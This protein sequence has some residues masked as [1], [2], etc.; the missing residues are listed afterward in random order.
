MASKRNSLF[1]VAL[2]STVTAG[3]RALQAAPLRFWSRK[4]LSRQPVFIVGAPRSGSTFL[5]Q[6]LTNIFDVAYIDNLAARFAD[7]LPLAMWVSRVCF[8][9]K[10]HNSFTSE[11]GR[12]QGL[13]SP[14]ECGAFWYRWL[15][16]DEHYVAPST[17][18]PYVAS[19]IA[20]EVR[21][22][23][24]S[25]RRPL[26][27]KNLN[28]GQ[29]LA[30]IHACFPDARIIHIRRSTDATVASI[31]RARRSAGVEEGEWW[32]VMP[33]GYRD[34]LGL[35]EEQM[36]RAQVDLIERQ[37]VDDRTLFQQGQWQ[38][39]LFEDLSPR[40]V[41]D[42]G[43]WLGLSY[44]PGAASPDKFPQARGPSASGEG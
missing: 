39:V 12:T 5:Y 28:A 32:S 17:V 30:L 4:P 33:R 43:A 2:R 40:V 9:S 11:A 15:P 29:R 3:L 38:E 19:Q 44:R 24:N 10:P 26:V 7:V 8:G 31:L 22:I 42:L 1:Y 25:L 41:D 14:S 18:D 35:P 13:H 27:F 23:S 20:S 37:I 6:S 16:R 21:A 34:L 36:V